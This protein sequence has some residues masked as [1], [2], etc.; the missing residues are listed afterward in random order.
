[1]S[2]SLAIASVTATLRWLL[3]KI[4]KIPEVTVLPLDKASEGIHAQKPRIN[5]FLYQ[6]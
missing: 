6:A 1:M 2:N 3:D 5:L 4:G